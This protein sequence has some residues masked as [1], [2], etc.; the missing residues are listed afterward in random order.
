MKPTHENADD[1]ALLESLLVKLG[2]RTGGELN[3]REDG[4]CHLEYQNDLPMLVELSDHGHAIIAALLLDEN[5]PQ[6]PDA[7][8]ELCELGWLGRETGGYALQVH[9]TLRSVCLWTSMPL[10][11][12]AIEDFEAELANL[13]KQSYRVRD[14]LEQNLGSGRSAAHEDP[15]RSGFSPAHGRFA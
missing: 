4:S 10:D 9:P 7:V 15:E 13:I 11:G 1:R 3:L 8:K 5:S 14:Y 2:Q 12:L 6:D